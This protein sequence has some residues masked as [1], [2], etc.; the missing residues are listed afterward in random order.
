M[1]Q[2]EGMC[3]KDEMSRIEAFGSPLSAEIP[4]ATTRHRNNPATW[5]TSGPIKKW[6]GF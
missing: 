1:I 6:K 3:G 5:R 2:G 4:R